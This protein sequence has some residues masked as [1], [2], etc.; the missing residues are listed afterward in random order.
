MSATLEVNSVRVS[1]RT[2]W[3]FVSLLSNGLRGVGEATLEGQSAAVEHAI[4][5]LRGDLL[6]RLAAD[7][8]AALRWLQGCAAGLDRVNATAVSGLEQALQDLL[9]SRRRARFTRCSGAVGER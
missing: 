8:R 1:E 9:G 4:E 5:S 6:A 7:G 2:V 3:T